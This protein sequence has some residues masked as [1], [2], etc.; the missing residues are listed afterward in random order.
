[1][2]PVKAKEGSEFSYVSQIKHRR[3]RTHRNKS[4]Q[5]QGE[6]IELL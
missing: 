4:H 3:A 6:Q 5:L 2:K 1:M